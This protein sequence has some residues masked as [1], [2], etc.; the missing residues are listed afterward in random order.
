M[1]LA[2]LLTKELTVEWRSRDIVA[3]TLTVAILVALAGYL[4]FAARVP[5]NAAVPGVLW[6]GVVFAAQVGLSRSFVVERQRGTLDGLLASPA[7]PLALWAAKL[8]LHF[9]TVLLVAIVTLLAL[10]LFFS[11]DAIGSAT[12]FL[13]VVPLGVL[14]VTLVTTMTGLIAMHGRN[15]VLLVP[16]LSLPAVYPLL[17]AAIPATELLLQDAPLASLNDPLRFLVLYDVILLV[18]AWL[19][20]PYLLEP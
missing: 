1:S 10:F 9:L 5:A 17:A 15:W 7:D 3:G 20:V 14:G 6:I 19:L 16:L 4:A 8:I 12:G 13:V 18:L 2:V 11:P